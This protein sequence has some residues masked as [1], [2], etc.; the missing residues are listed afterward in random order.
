MVSVAEKGSTQRTAE[1]EAFVRLPESVKIALEQQAGSSD[2]KTAKGS[3]CAVA[4]IA[5]ILAAKRTDELIP[6]CHSLPLQHVSVRVNWGCLDG[7]TALHIL[8]SATTTA[9]TGV[10]MEAL[11]AASVAA[12]TVYDMCKAQSHEMEIIGPRLLRKSGGKSEFR[13]PSRNQER[14]SPHGFQGELVFAEKIWGLLLAGGLSRRMGQIDKAWLPDL[15]SADPIPIWEG[16]LR[17]LQ[18]VTAHSWV[19]VREE[20][21]QEFRVRGADVLADLHEGQGPAVA[22]CEALK[23]I[24]ENA[25]LIV[26]ACDLPLFSPQALSYLLEKRDP[27]SYAS[28]FCSEDELPEPLVGV[29][30]KRS[31]SA[32]S[33]FLESGDNCPRKFLTQ[34]PCHLIRPP[35]A[36]WIFNANTPQ[37]R[38]AAELRRAES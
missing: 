2:L 31:L 8:T 29:W 14:T 28:T 26:L 13:R 4:E 24:P 38:R 20:S 36:D 21:A 3:V 16:L 10:E 37:E 17:H 34:V 11:T 12:L 9:S 25:A 5:G 27:G 35:N 32:L 7:Q 33:A 6:L 23:R 22:I 1:A 18:N 30:E 15:W 19:S